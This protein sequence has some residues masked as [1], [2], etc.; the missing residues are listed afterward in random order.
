M[1]IARDTIVSALRQR[2]QHARAD[3]VDRE[4]PEHVDPRRH[5]GLLATL[6]LN[7]TE[8]VEATAP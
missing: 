1:R 5:A 6:R 8:L 2:G 7:P 4:L 3:W